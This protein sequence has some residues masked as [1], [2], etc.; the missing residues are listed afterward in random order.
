M[1]QENAHPTVQSTKLAFNDKQ[2][3]SSGSLLLYFTAALLLHKNCNAHHKQTNLWN[4]RVLI[5]FLYH[6]ETR[7]PTF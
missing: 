7:Q 2:F 5:R 6:L 1:S 4:F 3:W